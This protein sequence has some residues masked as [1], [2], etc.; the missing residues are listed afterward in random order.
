MRATIAVIVALA[1]VPH[2]LDAAV[3]PALSPQAESAAFQQLAASVPLG[4][5]VKVRTTTGRRLTAILIVVEDEHIVLKRDAR[6]PEPAV[7][8][9]YG[10]IA[11]FQRHEPGV[12]AG[13]AIGVGLAAGVGAV[14]TLFAIAFA[15]NN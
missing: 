5:R 14:L 8:I 1:L 3:Q 11:A 10:E 9:G 12:S 4:S 15:L 2:A 7:R 6:V 13:K